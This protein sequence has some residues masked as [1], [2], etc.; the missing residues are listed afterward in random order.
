MRHYEA[1][2]EK[3]SLLMEKHSKREQ[4][5]EVLVRSSQRI[6]SQDLIEEAA[7]WK[8]M[9]E[10]K[11]LEINKF[12]EELDSI[13]EVLRELQRQGVKLPVCSLRWCLKLPQ[14]CW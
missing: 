5:L 6:A 12:R 10:A 2:E 11:N 8:N 1:L 7:R 14:N 4:E 13:L 9:V 3:I